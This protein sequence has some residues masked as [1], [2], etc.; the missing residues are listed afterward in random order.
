MQLTALRDSEDAPLDTDDSDSLLALWTPDD[1]D[2]DAALL[3]QFK[4]ALAHE[5]RSVRMAAVLHIAEQHSVAALRVMLNALVDDEL[6]VT[7]VIVQAL[8]KAGDRVAPLLLDFLHS[9][10]RTRQAVAVDMLRLLKDPR[11]VPSLA[12]LLADEAPVQAGMVSGRMCDLAERA[13]LAISTPEALQAVQTWR[14]RVFQA[15]AAA[16]HREPGRYTPYADAPGTP[17][18]D[19]S[20]PATLKR[21]FSRL[22]A[23]MRGDDWQARQTAARAI[24]EQARALK[25]QSVPTVVAYL[26]S[27]LDDPLHEIRWAMVEALAWIR[28]AAAVPA[29][30]ERLNDS[31][32]TVRVAAVRALM[33]IGDVSAAAALAPLLHDR[34][35]SVR[36]A[37]VEALGS[38][39]RRQDVDHLLDALADSEEFVRAA[40]VAALQRLGGS[41]AAAMLATTALNDRS[42]RVRWLAAD[43]LADMAGPSEVR[44][45]APALYD[46]SRPE[47]EDS[48][49]CDRIEAAL[50]RIN[51]PTSQHFLTDWRARQQQRD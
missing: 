19:P 35:V 23:A 41:S 16:N 17:D 6:L 30:T 3:A 31:A 37:A 1:T 12:D 45:I 47:W 34:E 48:R 44:A 14:K 22:V 5:D 38:I 8:V 13:L 18:T 33:E 51:S 43:A 36:E 42:V 26:I 28:D 25:D 49:V 11:A 32:W 7:D 10:D 40:A 29:L 50:I 9:P 20:K 24:Q 46:T 21:R 15:H 2:D 39:G 4:Q 27:L